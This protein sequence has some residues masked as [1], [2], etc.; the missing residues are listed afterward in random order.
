MIRG[1]R[2]PT[3]AIEGTAVVGPFFWSSYDQND[4]DPNLRKSSLDREAT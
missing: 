1:M 2:L 4:E 3:S